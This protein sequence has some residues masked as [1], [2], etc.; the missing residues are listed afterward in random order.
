MLRTFYF[1]LKNEGDDRTYHPAPW[2][3]M[4]LMESQPEF[5]W[6]WMREGP[7][8]I[9]QSCMEVQMRGYSLPQEEPLKGMDYNLVIIDIG[10]HATSRL[11]WK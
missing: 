3:S 10:N 1:S 7:Y 2:I 11:I 8:V 9:P 6:Y 4:K 5:I